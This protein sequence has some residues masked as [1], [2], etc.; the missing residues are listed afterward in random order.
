MGRIVII[1][2]GRTGRGFIGRLLAE[3]GAEF[4]FVDK[5]A[6]LVDALNAQGC[7][8]VH[9]FG[10]VRLPFSVAGYQACTWQDA[11][12]TDAELIFTAV[13]GSNLA[14]V[15]HSLAEKL[16]PG[17]AYYI[18]AAENAK[19]PS[20][21][22]KDA[23]LEGGDS[24]V[25]A[26]DGTS[27]GT[28][29][30]LNEA[31]IRVSEATVF[32][33]TIESG[34]ITGAAAGGEDAAG[35]AVSGENASDGAVS[36]EA[37]ADDGAPARDLSIHSENYP[38]LQFNADLLGDYVPE[39]AAIRPVK[40]FGDFLTRKLFT[41]NAASGIIS[42]LGALKGYENYAEA[43]NDP[44]ILALMDHN[45]AV[46]NSVLCK[47]FGYDPKDQEEFAKLSRD[48]FL[49]RTIVDSIERNAHDP[50][51][52]I[53]P[54]ER[55]MGPLRLILQ[56]G[57]DGSVLEKTAAALLCYR[58]V[59]EDKWDQVRAQL[60]PEEILRQ[61]GG[62]T[63]E[64]CLARILKYYETYNEAVARGLQNLQL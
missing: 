2:A 33:T 31:D 48:K 32:C 43:A 12:L 8:D 26:A 29:S 30:R 45:Y 11:D 35:G 57:G 56:E 60:S 41:Y 61:Y 16:V 20:K 40:G 42:Y 17:K 4:T 10:D 62:L 52:K 23:I 44:E 6:A 38:Y 63:D 13:G 59:N 64:A 21:T 50:L 24:S 39:V 15:G 19:G 22:L 3:G 55:I 25:S 14:D 54:N 36:G 18:I 28:G 53:G 27:A 58:G 7:Y 9:F 49:N 5:D 47:L 46:S 1:G 34:A 51:R 37:S